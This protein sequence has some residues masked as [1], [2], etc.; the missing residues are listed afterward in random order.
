MMKRGFWAPALLASSSGRPQAQTTDT[1]E[2]PPSPPVMP[3]TRRLK[4]PRP[5]LPLNRPGATALERAKADSIYRQALAEARF[6]HAP[7]LPADDCDYYEVVMKPGFE[8]IIPGKLTRILGFDGHY[9]G[10]T[11]IAPRERTAVVRFV[12]R[13]DDIV[14]PHYHGGHTPPTPTASR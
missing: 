11:F 3:F 5:Y 10:P 13:G 1:G 6:R 4:I 12:N 14:S 8:E 7:R 2:L 9:P